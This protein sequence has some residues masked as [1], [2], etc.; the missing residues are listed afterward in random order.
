MSHRDSI[1][2]VLLA[3]V[4]LLSLVHSD[5]AS[6]FNPLQDR[7]GNARLIEKL[8]CSKLLILSSRD[9][10]SEYFAPGFT[11]IDDLR[12]HVGGN[13]YSL[14]VLFRSENFGVLPTSCS[15]IR[16]PSFFPIL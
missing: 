15:N 13:L 10:S 8:K 9:A 3:S 16:S 7:R 12:V 1:N 11:L 2:A 5:E 4:V 6:A 14:H